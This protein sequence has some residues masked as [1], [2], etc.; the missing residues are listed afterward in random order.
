MK[1]LLNFFLK[2]FIDVSVIHRSKQGILNFISIVHHKTTTFFEIKL[3]P[4]VIRTLYFCFQ[5]NYYSILVTITNTKVLVPPNTCLKLQTM[6][7]KT[8]RNYWRVLM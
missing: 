2:M 4:I 1:P 6:R 8:G 7:G 5:D 3:E